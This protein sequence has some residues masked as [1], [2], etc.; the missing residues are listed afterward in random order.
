MPFIDSVGSEVFV[1]QAFHIVEEQV[2]KI[3]LYHFL[4]Q[5]QCLLLHEFTHL[6]ILCIT[7][8]HLA[9]WCHLCI[10]VFFVT[11]AV[12]GANG[13]VIDQ[14]FRLAR[15]KAAPHRTFP[16]VLPYCLFDSMGA[17]LAQGILSLDEVFPLVHHLF[18]LS[19]LCLTPSDLT[20]LFLLAGALPG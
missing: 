7:L 16:Q 10:V 2:T 18:E 12:I 13:I 14:R 19:L 6:P 9:H 17:L 8:I 20:L 11:V 5:I 3:M 15:L 4:L 1:L